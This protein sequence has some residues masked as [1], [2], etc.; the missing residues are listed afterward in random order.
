DRA[1]DRDARRLDLA[2]GDPPR[3]RDLQAVVTERDLVAALGATLEVALVRL[4]ELRAFGR[5]HR[6]TGSPGSALRGRKAGLLDGQD[7]AV[8]DPRLDADAAVR[9]VRLGEAV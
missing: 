5:E 4:A 2:R 1:R 3:R 7:L 9:G 6:H 8:E